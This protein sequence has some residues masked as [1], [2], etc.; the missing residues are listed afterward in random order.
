MD[1][2]GQGYMSHGIVVSYR[3]EERGDNGA[4]N[5]NATQKGKEGRGRIS[6]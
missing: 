4:V 5:P 2:G 1:G 6:K 3:R